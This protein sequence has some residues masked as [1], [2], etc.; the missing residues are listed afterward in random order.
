MDTLKKLFPFSFKEFDGKSFALT[1]VGYVVAGF[2]LGLILSLLGRIPLI[3]WIFNVIN[4][5]L[6]VYL[7][8]GVVLA[9]LKFVK[10]LK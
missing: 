6:E 7:T 5:L 4:W 9:I 1:I 8:A 3:G 2:V 10:V